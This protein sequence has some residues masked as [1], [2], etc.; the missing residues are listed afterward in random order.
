MYDTTKLADHL[1]QYEGC[2]LC[3]TGISIRH[4]TQPQCNMNIMT[5]ILSHVRRGSGVLFN[6]IFG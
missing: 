5:L 3:R 6:R 4:T 2:I 1:Q